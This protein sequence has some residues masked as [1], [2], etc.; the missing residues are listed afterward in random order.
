[1]LVIVPMRAFYLMLILPSP[2]RSSEKNKERTNEWTQPGTTTTTDSIRRRSLVGTED[3][4]S[5][6]VNSSVATP[7]GW[8]GRILLSVPLEK[9]RPLRYFIFLPRLIQSISEWN[10]GRWGAYY[11]GYREKEGFNGGVQLTIRDYAHANREL[12]K[13]LDDSI[14]SLQGSEPYLDDRFAVAIFIV[15]AVNA[16]SE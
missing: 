10:S 12:K 16:F 11:L 4:Y 8:D 15:W 9:K 1:M 6:I 5:V 13:L 14:G 3:K 2:D 7:D